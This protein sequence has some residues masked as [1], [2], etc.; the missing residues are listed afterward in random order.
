MIRYDLACAQGHRFDGWFRSS[1]DFDDQAGRNLLAC[2]VCGG[3]E[4]AKVLMAPALAKGAGGPAAAADAPADAP[5]PAPAP[6]QEVALVDEKQRRLRA[7]LR[8]LH[9]E[10]TKNSKD[11][12]DRFADEARKIHY[13]EVERA[14]IHGRATPEEARSLAEEG[15]AF[16]PLPP[17][18]D[19]RN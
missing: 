4:V 2:P 18:P 16:H 14:T 17:L 1:T 11:V 3:A 19:E 13:G 9:A 8:D 5:S 12:G 7:M 15:I 6:A 10:L